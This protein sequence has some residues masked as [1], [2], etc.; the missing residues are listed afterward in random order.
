MRPYVWAFDLDGTLLNTWDLNRQAYETVGIKIPES[1]HGLPWQEWLPDYCN[2]NVE[3]AAT[4]HRAKTQLYLRHLIESDLVGMELPALEV[5]RE[6]FADNPTRVKILT[7]AS[8]LSTRR[9]MNRLGF[10]AI[11]YHAELQ[12]D[13]RRRHL[14]AWSAHA[15]VTYVDDSPKTLMRLRE[16]AVDV[17]LVQYTG[18]D[19]T[20]LKQEMGVPTWTQ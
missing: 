5:A 4:L 7:A 15:S 12:Y 10:D 1:A 3:I 20:T 11:E 18:Q 19:L 17:R 2:G 6:L 8:I 13:V 16:D 14:A 9:L